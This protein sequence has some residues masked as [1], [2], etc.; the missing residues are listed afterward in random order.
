MCFVRPTVL[1]VV[2]ATLLAFVCVLGPAGA[3]LAHNG[4]GGENSDYRIE[5][6]GWQGDHTGVTLRVVELG[7]RLELE[8]TTAESVLVLGYEGEPYVR[9][10]AD[11]VFENTNSPAHYLNRD[12]F[13][14]TNPPASAS[15]AAEVSWS[16]VTGGSTFRWHDHRAHWMSTTPRADVQADPDVQH[17]VFDANRIDLVIDGRDAAAIVRVTWLPQPERAVWLLVATLLGLATAAVLVLVDST[18]PLIPVLAVAGAGAS[19]VGQGPSTLRHGLGGACLL[20]A[21]A[22]FPL[23][24]PQLAIAAAVGGGVLAATHLEVFEH[25]LL[26]GWPSGQWQRVAI[27]LG[28][29]LCLGVVAS[30]LV[31]A[32]GPTTRATG[33]TGSTEVIE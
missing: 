17:V 1:R 25:E 3:A 29:G 4:T 12:R 16:L 9:L 21:A 23:R 32:L 8:R 7:N 11:G 2:L 14:S 20:L 22:A 24:R 6:T 5:I 19:L 10:D 13:A 18:I 15:A 26:A 27:A 28:L 31:S 33:T 30:A